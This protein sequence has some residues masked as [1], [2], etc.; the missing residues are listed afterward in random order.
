VAL[1]VCLPW[2][3]SLTQ[4]FAFL[5]L[6]G[7]PWTSCFDLT[8]TNIVSSIFLSVLPYLNKAC[9]GLAN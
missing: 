1:A 9:P 2:G 3:S 5:V 4:A 7:T 8:E 6:D